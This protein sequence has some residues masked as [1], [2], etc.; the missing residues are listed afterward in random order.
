MFTTFLKIIYLIPT[1]LFTKNKMR[2]YSYNVAYR[3]GCDAMV[4]LR[5][6]LDKNAKSFLKN[7]ENLILL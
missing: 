6:K 3:T 7:P 1:L 4:W 5:E 2:M